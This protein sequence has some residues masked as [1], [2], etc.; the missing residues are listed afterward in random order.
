MKLLVACSSCA[1]QYDATG[2]A[3]GSRFRC[4]CGDVVTVPEP[5]V[6][7]AR[8]VR[9]SACGAPRGGD[10]SSCG[11][12][13]SS[14]TLHERDL[15]TIC[16]QCFARVSDRARYC[17][18]CGTGIA[19]EDSVLSTGSVTERSCP[20]CDD[21]PLVGRRLGSLAVSVLE[22]GGCAGLWLGADAFARLEELA[23]RDQRSELASVLAGDAS[24]TSRPVPVQPPGPLYRPCVVCSALMHRV[25]YGKRSG[26]IVDLCKEHG[27]WFDAE[28]LQRVVT[29]IRDGGLERSEARDAEQTREDTRRAAIE[30]PL[31]EPADVWRRRSENTIDSVLEI[32]DFVGD[33][34]SFRH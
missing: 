33:L 11:F 23:Q 31:P 4:H 12:C 17:P 14:F 15:Q 27:V 6:H 34:L 30:L 24:A 28:E 13:G 18:E 3:V 29:W 8:V 10:E 22:C 20:A 9:C 19:P 16:P 32:V 25:N 21:Q 1:R 26:V 5:K 2:R 7:E